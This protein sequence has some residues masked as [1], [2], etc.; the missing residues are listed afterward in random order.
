MRVF[1]T[2]AADKPLAGTRAALVE[3]LRRLKTMHWADPG[4]AEL[5]AEVAKLEEQLRALDRGRAS[6]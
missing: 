2:D 4:D 1:L 6:S 3:E 5:K